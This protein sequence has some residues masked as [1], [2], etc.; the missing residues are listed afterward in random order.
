M[1]RKRAKTKHGDMVSRKFEGRV[2]LHTAHFREKARASS[3]AESMREMTGRKY[4]VV[5]GNKSGWAV[6]SR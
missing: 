6:Y 1:G 4:R 5:R 2:F 3:F